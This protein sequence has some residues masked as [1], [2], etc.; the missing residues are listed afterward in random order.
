M[1]ALPG[2]KREISLPQADESW[3]S[4]PRMQLSNEAL[5]SC[6]NVEDKISWPGMQYRRDIGRF[7]DTLKANN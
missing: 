5:A 6:Y 3:E 1:P 4:P 2:L 7:H